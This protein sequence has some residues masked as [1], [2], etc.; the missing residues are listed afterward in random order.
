M[1]QSW[2]VNSCR[3]TSVD[4]EA[5]SFLMIIGFW[6]QNSPNPNDV[7]LLSMSSGG[8]PLTSLACIQTNIQE[9]VDQEIA[10]IT[11]V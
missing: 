3:I 8:K 1:N 9:I 7:T 2:G 5:R 11:D 10:T 4:K 6:Q